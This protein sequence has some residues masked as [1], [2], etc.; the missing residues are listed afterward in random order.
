MKNWKLLVVVVCALT[1]SA[2]CA[3]EPRKPVELPKG[4]E[5]VT[6]KLDKPAAAG[7]VLPGSR[8]DVVFKTADPK[9][10]VV[11]EDLLVYAVDT[12]ANKGEVTATSYSVGMTKTQAQLA[13]VMTRDGAKP[14]VILRKPDKK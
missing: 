4:I 5:L 11:L 3:D 14:Q 2:S 8:V 12:T 9:T 6:L 13:A 1:V 10:T 7:F